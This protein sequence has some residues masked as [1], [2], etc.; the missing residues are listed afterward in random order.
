MADSGKSL[1]D[2]SINSN[3]EYLNWPGLKK[4]LNNINIL[5]EDEWHLNK[6]Y[7]N[8]PGLKELVENK[9]I[10]PEDEWHLNKE[11]LNWPGIQY[12]WNKKIEP[13]IYQNTS[14]V[15]G[16]IDDENWYIEYDASDGQVYITLNED[17]KN[18]YFD[19]D[20]SC[21]CIQNYNGML[22]VVV[23][24]DLSLMDDGFINNTTGKLYVNFD[25]IS[26]SSI[27]SC[28]GNGFWDND[29]G[30]DNDDGWVN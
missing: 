28:F 5:P 1:L 14:V 30:W 12:L 23:N 11:Y 27:Y 17:N 7:L 20:G 2:E 25:V 10:L 29:A 16:K 9:N 22:Q 18:F 3:T 8:W 19:Q 26:D 13:A 15:K 4:L 21:G 6:E 24:R